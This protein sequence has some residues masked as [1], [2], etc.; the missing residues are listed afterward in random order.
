M[1]RDRNFGSYEDLEALYHRRPSAWVEPDGDWGEGEVRLVEIPTR[2][3]FEDNIV[4]FWVPKNPPKP[5]EPFSFSYTLRWTS[6]EPKI[7]PCGYCVMTRIGRVPG[8]PLERKIILNFSGGDLENLGADSGVEV[9]LPQARSIDFSPG[10]GKNSLHRPVVHRRPDPFRRQRSA[11]HPASVFAP[12]LR[13]THRDMD[14]HASSVSNSPR[15][16]EA[17]AWQQAAE[18]V[19]ALLRAYRV[20][21][22][23]HRA[24]ILINVLCKAREIHQPGT[25]HPVE[26][27]IGIL[28]GALKHQLCSALNEKNFSRARLEL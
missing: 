10:R 15:D 12:R 23:E 27:S 17:E 28:S 22:L 4:A 26:L 9:L 7:S 16:A 3:E 2:N 6:R 25:T 21:S 14:A 19:D 13:H 11:R 18:R 8:E 1:Q 24:N 20:K 5:G